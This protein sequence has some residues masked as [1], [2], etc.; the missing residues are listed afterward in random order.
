MPIVETGKTLIEKLTTWAR[1]STDDLAQALIKRKPHTL[2][3][4]DDG[5]IPNHP[6]WPLIIYKTPVRL[7][8]AYDPAAIF[9]V[10]F[11]SNKWGKSWRNGIYPYVHYHSRIHEV[12]G[13]ASGEAT[14]QFGGNRG[15]PLKIKAG[16]VSILPAGTGHKLLN[17]SSD[18]LVVGAYPP[19]GTYDLCTTSEDHDRALATIPHVV[20]PECDPVYGAHGPLL[21]I[22]R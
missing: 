20:R 3:F 9:E 22:W 1:P 11:A 13:I 6:S 16:D 4:E 8:P 5:V 10:L 2:S 7:L 14:V 18:F 12:L 19:Q 15:R 21:K 17:A